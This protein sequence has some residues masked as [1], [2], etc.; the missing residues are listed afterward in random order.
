M[1]P[2]SPALSAMVARTVANAE[3][4]AQVPIDPG[5]LETSLRHALS[6]LYRA[7][8]RIVTFAPHVALRRAMALIELRARLRRS[9]GHAAGRVITLGGRQPGFAMRR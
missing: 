6:D 8:P 2:I 9:S 7:R 1:H 3:R 4:S 5:E